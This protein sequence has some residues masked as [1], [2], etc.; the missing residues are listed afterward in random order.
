MSR[1]LAI[2]RLQALGRR[3]GALWPLVV[4]SIAFVVNLAIFGA[5]AGA[6][7]SK[8]VTGGLAS[9]YITSLIFG[10]VAI[11]QQFPFALGLSVTR[12]EFSAALG[13]FVLVQ[14]L[15]FAVL[16]VILQ[17][18]EDA[19]DGWGLRLRF[20]GLGFVDDYGVPAQ[21]LI[22]AVPL[23]LM[24]LIGIAFGVVY[25]RWKVNGLFAVLAAVLLVPGIAVALITRAASWPSIGHWLADR[26]ALTLFA[27]L[28]LGPALLLALLSWVT[29][30]RATA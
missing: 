1:L 19:T 20:F 10:A 29:L 16:L 22:Y 3:D 27:A 12:R 8:P 4:L 9:I 14:S 5:A 28:P 6:F 23:L 25:V 21:L 17:A 26:S 11:V 15:G 24:T 13:L 30:R 7:D 18:V 2:A